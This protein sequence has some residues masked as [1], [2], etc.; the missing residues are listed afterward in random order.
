MSADMCKRKN[1]KQVALRG[2][3]QVHLHNGA[4]RSKCLEEVWGQNI[5]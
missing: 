2:Y 4:I 1:A 3:G 5:Y